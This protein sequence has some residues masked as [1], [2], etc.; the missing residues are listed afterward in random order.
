MTPTDWAYVAGILDGEAHVAIKRVRRK[1]GHSH[2][3]GVTV[4]MVDEDLVRWLHRTFGG[5]V[6]R[7]R[8]RTPRH[9]PSFQWTLTGRAAVALLQAVAPYLRIK[10]LHAALIS[11]FY[12][13]RTASGVR[14]SDAERALRDTYYEAVRRLNYGRLAA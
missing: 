12:A 1:A 6:T 3:A 14:L 9:R 2:W 11:E 13:R 8:A 5:S 4:K 10:R 7:V